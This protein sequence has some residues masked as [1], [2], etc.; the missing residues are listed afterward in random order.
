VNTVTELAAQL[1]A[2]QLSS[3]ELVDAAAAAIAARNEE[4][5]A[6]VHLELDAARTTAVAV[7]R[8]RA[9]GESLGPL[10]GI[11]FGVKDLED[12]AG[13]PTGRGSRW[14]RGSPPA[15]RD[16]L[17]VARLRAA[18]AVPVG[19]TATPEFGAWAYTASPAYGVTRNPWALDRTPG[20]SSGGSAAAVASGMVPFATASDGGGSIR[21][22][23]GFTG[24]PA[25]KPMYGRVPT[26]GVTHL[27][28]NAVNFT[29]ARTAADTALLLDVCAG[30]SVYDRTALPMP[31]GSYVDAVHALDVSGLRVAW[32]ADLGFATVDPRVV[33]VVQAAAATLIE[34][35]GMR[36]VDVDIALD[37]YI[38]L[39][40]HMEGPEPWVGRAPGLWPERADELDPRVRP[41]WDAGS[42]VTLP[43]WAE[44]V[45]RRRAF[46]HRVAAL[47]E[48][49]DVLLTPMSACPPFAAE[50]PMP[51]SIRGADGAMVPTHG[52]MSVIFP[53]LANICNL[54]AISIPAGL[55]D[56]GTQLPVGLQAI[57]PRFREDICLRL[58]H[59]ME[60]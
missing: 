38:E 37:D 31:V 49:F 46:E 47:F 43:K 48:Q 36:V 6:F 8:A 44:A 59:L 5:N 26:Y 53:M 16:D 55:V 14:Y 23:G 45:T 42:R 7:D 34:R 22:P 2:R 51:T 24:L 28:Q 57:A 32:S 4:L 58:A 40:V 41:G 25:L 12:C 33:H 21:T 1:A 20:G 54:P 30:P 50:G 39:Y 56:D 3:V 29:L 11:P 17:H 27:A 15:E 19:K 9:G 18:G 10:A 35:S 13:M 52:G 60:T